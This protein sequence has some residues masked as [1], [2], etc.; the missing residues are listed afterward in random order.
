MRGARN[1]PCITTIAAAEAVVLGIESMS[2]G[3][4][5]KALQDYYKKK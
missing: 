1:I 3:Y 5:V 2:Q 4:G